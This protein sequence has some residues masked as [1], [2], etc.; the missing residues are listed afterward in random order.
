VKPTTPNQ[1]N[2]QTLQMQSVLVYVSF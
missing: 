1:K 2:Q